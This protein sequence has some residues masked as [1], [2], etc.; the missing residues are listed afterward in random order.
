[1]GKWDPQSSDKVAASETLG[2]R[3]FDQPTLAG[4]VGQKAPLAVYHLRNFQ[5]TR[6]GESTSLDRLG[7]SNP[8]PAVLG[9]LEPRARAAAAKVKPQRQFHGWASIQARRLQEDTKIPFEVRPSPLTGIEL[10]ENKFHADAKCLRPHEPYV[11]ALHLRYLFETHGFFQAPKVTPV[12]KSGFVHR[13][14][15]AVSEAFGRVAAKFR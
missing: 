7:R 8:E 12:E 15:L 13:C 2:R 5:E 9:Y 3:I 11:V 6:V 14:L 4:A 10:E 1:M